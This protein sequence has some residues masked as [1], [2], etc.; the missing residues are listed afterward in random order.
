[1]ETTRHQVDRLLR[2][3]DLLREDGGQE[4]TQ[5]LVLA[6]V[7]LRYVADVADDPRG[8]PT[9]EHLKR[10]LHESDPGV[11]LRTALGAWSGV[12][13]NLTVDLRDESDFASLRSHAHR[14]A[15]GALRGLIDLL[16]TIDLPPWKLYEECLARFSEDRVGG[17]YFT[18][19]EIV[20]T[21]VELV[22]PRP[23]EKVYD[24]A[25]GSAGLLIAAAGSASLQD[26]KPADAR[27]P[28]LAG[29][30]IHQGNLKVAAMN[31]IL[32]G[33]ENDL[34]HGLEL[35]NSLSYGSWPGEQYDVVLA[36]PP[37]GS[38]RW[39]EKLD[40]RSIS[41]RYG[42][43][44]KNHADFAWVQHVL[45]SLNPTGRAAILLANGASFRGS[46]EHRIRA[47]LVRDDVLAAVIQLPSGIFP[48]TRIPAC[49]W[50]FNKRKRDHSKGRVLFVDAQD[51]GVQV[52]RSRR[53]L[54]EEDVMRVMGT[55]RD[56]SEGRKNDDPE[57]CR[58]V[59][60]ED[61][62]AAEYNLVPSRYVR[63]AVTVAQPGDGER[64]VRELTEELHRHFA[65]ASRLEQELRDVLG[66]F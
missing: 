43:P 59:S 58:E 55:F 2:A 27:T 8:R 15:E 32:H 39:Q 18:P 9:W 60:L 31:L 56:W 24:P 45:G 23:T 17:E 26:R 54:T 6:A 41:W 40:R 20:R 61:I 19:R 65:E 22:K 64:R 53:V 21:M 63:P 42:E 66:E 16:D 10:Q 49:L 48:H 7:F 13:G 38:S 34:P 12:Y 50:V 62:E 37:F 33:L 5:Q 52:S 29:R 44:P 25:C 28:R 57:W 30:D 46:A 4:A 36:N 11:V 35:G 1:M 14:R 47:G 3:V 51:V